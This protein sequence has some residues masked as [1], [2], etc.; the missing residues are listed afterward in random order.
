MG[1]EMCIRDRLLDEQ[2]DP[3]QAGRDLVQAPDWEQQGRPGLPGV[4]LRGGEEEGRHR[5]ERAG[6][7]EGFAVA[8]KGAREAK[9]PRAEWWYDASTLIYRNFCEHE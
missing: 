8:E 2:E 6:G 9:S 7:L 4:H 3:W 5:R 1:S